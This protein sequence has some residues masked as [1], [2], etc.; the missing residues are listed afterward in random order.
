MFQ[1]S[2]E[3]DNCIGVGHW[4][5]NNPSKESLFLLFGNLIL[6]SRQKQFLTWVEI[7]QQ[8]GLLNEPF[9]KAKPWSSNVDLNNGWLSGFIDAEGCFHA[10]FKLPL[11]QK[12]QIF[13]F[14]VS[15]SKWTKEHYQQF[16]TIQWK[17]K[18]SQRMILTQISSDQTDHVFQTILLLFHSEGKLSR[19]QNNT[20][21]KTNKRYVRITFSTLASQEKI[22]EYLTRYPLK[23]I[24]QISFKRWCR[25]YARRKTK[26]HLSPK[27]TKRLFRLVK[28][29][30]DHSKKAYL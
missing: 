24:K 28:A 10:Q 27:G 14:P 13:E 2:Q 29:I 1:V 11:E 15:K 6:T 20:T 16:E 19:F 9:D 8:K 3:T 21:V 5:T 7:A 12:K 18:L 26:V 23:T 30:N 25:V 4:K 17:G 22:I